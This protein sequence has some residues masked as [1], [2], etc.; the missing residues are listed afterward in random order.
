MHRMQTTQTFLSTP[1]ARRATTV[2][3]QHVYKKF[4]FYPRPLRGGRLRHSS[5]LQ[6]DKGYFYPRPLRGGRRSADEVRRHSRDISI[7]ALCEEGDPQAVR[8]HG[9]H[10]ISIHAL[11]EEG[12][13]G[14]GRYCNDG[15]N[16]YPRPLRGGR[17]ES[18]ER[19]NHR[20]FISIHALCEEGDEDDE[21]L[22]KRVQE[23]LSTPSAR[24][25]TQ[26]AQQGGPSVEISIHAL[27]EE[28]DIKAHNADIDTEDF[29]P[30]PLRGGRRCSW[31]FRRAQSQNFYPRPL[32]GGR[33]LAGV[34]V[35]QVAVISI[36][37]LCEEGDL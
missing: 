16:F 26:N 29:Y 12:D 37:A 21:S 2:Q 33:H 14:C 23:F 11:C 25:A 35:N 22:R 20:L 32:R 36:H 24:R 31:A 27:C 30:R 4:Y 19:R 6:Q 34:L 9:G 13:A 8:G 17:R 15:Q 1:S 7:H 10:Q 3:R 28:G 5:K 18:P